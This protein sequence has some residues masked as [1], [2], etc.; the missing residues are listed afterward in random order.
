MMDNNT[1]YA[2]IGLCKCGVATTMTMYVP[3]QADRTARHVSDAI[4]DGLTIERV[5]V[6]V[7]RSLFGHC[8]CAKTESDN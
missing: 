1:G 4:R 6:E 3:G 7:A 5:T 8:T 2:Y